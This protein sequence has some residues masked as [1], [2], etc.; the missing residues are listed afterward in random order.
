MIERN[1]TSLGLRPSDNRSAI[2]AMINAMDD[3]FGFH[4]IIDPDR[5]PIEAFSGALD[6][7]AEAGNAIAFTEAANQR[8]R[9][10]TKKEA[11]P[12]I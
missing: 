10:V 11:E 6:F 5:D 8:R 9:P 12:K 4:A 2:A 7:I 1:A 3:G